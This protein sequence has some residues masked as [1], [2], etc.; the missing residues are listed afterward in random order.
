VPSKRLADPLGFANVDNSGAGNVQANFIQGWGQNIYNGAYVEK[1]QIVMY[2]GSATPVVNQGQSGFYTRYAVRAPE[3]GII[4]GLKAYT[5]N[6]TTAATTILAN[7]TENLFSIEGGSY[8]YSFANTNA[9]VAYGIADINPADG[10]Y[11]R[12]VNSDERAMKVTGGVIDTG[13]GMKPNERPKTGEYNAI[14]LTNGGFP[15]IAYY[16][17]TN[18]K[19]KLA[20]S[21]RATPILAADW[22]I[23]ENVIDPLDPSWF[24][25]G[26][27][28]SI[29]I[30][31]TNR[32]HMAALNSNDKQLVYITGMINTGAAYNGAGTNNSDGVLYD[33]SVQVVDSLGNVGRWCKISLDRDNKP[34]ISYQDMGNQGS[35]DGVKMAFQNDTLYPKPKMDRSNADISGW[36]T[37]HVPARYRVEDAKISVE[38]FPTQATPAGALNS[39]IWSAAIG[40]LASDRYRIAYYV[41]R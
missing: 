8:L 1:G 2:I 32:I 20:V 36:E 28:I 14:A 27:Y 17:N 29:C 26:E 21:T 41:C 31:N 38:C 13:V 12:I 24:G 9:L 30:D 34:W 16:D 39:K 15:V 10:T 5:I 3:R 33:V 19:L 35:M 22:K 11:T 25:T 40:Y 37:M 18:K 6:G 23:K 4:R 7:C